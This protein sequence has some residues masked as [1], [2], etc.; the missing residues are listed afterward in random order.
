MISNP[1]GAPTAP[2]EQPQEPKECGRCQAG[3]TKDG[4]TC[5]D[6]GGV[7][8]EQPGF[9]DVTDEEYFADT[10]FVSNSMLKTFSASVLRYHAKYIAKSLK[11]EQSDELRLGSA[12]HAM[13]FQPH[14]DLVAV[15]PK[16]DRRTKAGKETWWF[17]ESENEGKIL[18]NSD[19]YMTLT[20][21][22]KAIQGN[23]TTKDLIETDGMME[24]A[25]RW[26]D[27]STGLWCKGKADLITEDFIL[28]VKTIAS[29]E[30]WPKHVA[31]FGYHRQQ[32]F[33][34]SGD[35]HVSRHYGH[36]DKTKE[37]VFVV[38]EKEPPHEAAAFVLTDDAVGQGRT[39]NL[40]AMLELVSR[41]KHDN[42]KSRYYHKITKTSLPRWAMKG[43]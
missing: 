18:V 22:A 30:N 2:P 33:Y 36:H 25:F 32:A 16:V 20:S 5:T 1:R 12:F 29:I 4:E 11:E 17:F 6:C 7:A 39:E 37:F 13:I 41:M 40:D 28:D 26:Q 38:V 35:E 43:A 9:W 31:N 19:E 10:R 8:P 42:W 15:G 14:K 34:Q 21:M 24:T 27:E 23:P 3:D